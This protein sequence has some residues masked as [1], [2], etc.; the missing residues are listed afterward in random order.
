MS[1]PL[2][3]HCQSNQVIKKGLCVNNTGETR[4]R[5]KCK[6]CHKTFPTK[7]VLTPPEQAEMDCPKCNSSNTF[8]SGQPR[9]R[10]HGEV[11]KCR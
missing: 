11:Q 3:P 2:C 7:N 9:Q 6:S 4:Q 8:K 1:N 10:I 5:Y